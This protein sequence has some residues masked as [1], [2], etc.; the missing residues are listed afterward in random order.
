MDKESLEQ[1]GCLNYIET[2]KEILGEL[3]HP[4]IVRFYGEMQDAKSIHFMTEVSKSDHSFMKKRRILNILLKALV[5]GQLYDLIGDEKFF[6][7]EWSK[8][9][10]ACVVSAF[11]KMHAK[12]IGK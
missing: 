3:N 10:S 8:F 11:D 1:K 6:S 9:Y 5:G 12:K 4:F 2:E 7:E